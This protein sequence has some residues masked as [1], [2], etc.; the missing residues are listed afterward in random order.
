M[1]RCRNVLRFDLG[2]QEDCKVKKLPILPWE[3]RKG[4]TTEPRKRRF[5]S[6]LRGSVVV[7]ILVLRVDLGLC[8]PFLRQFTTLFARYSISNPWNEYRAES[9]VGSPCRKKSPFSLDTLA[10][11]SII[12][13]ML[14]ILSL[15][16]KYDLLLSTMEKA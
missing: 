13:I 9:A 11:E 14:L 8:N 7:Q 10:V 12:K 1:M 5:F 2:D 16:T 6:S 4:T 3:G 15:D